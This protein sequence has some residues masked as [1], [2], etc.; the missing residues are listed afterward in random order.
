MTETLASI[1]F[2]RHKVIG[3]PHHFL[4]QTKWYHRAHQL[5]FYSYKTV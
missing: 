4:F 2:F 5:L 1:A 3:Q